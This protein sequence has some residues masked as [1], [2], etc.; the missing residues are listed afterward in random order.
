MD[1]SSYPPLASEVSPY[2]KYEC[3]SMERRDRSVF[4]NRWGAV[5]SPP[6]KLP[7][8]PHFQTLHDRQKTVHLCG[9]NPSTG[10]NQLV[11]AA[12][13]CRIKYSGL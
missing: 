1:R 2:K 8:S 5:G 4:H 9:W 3:V 10:D 6:V 7:F 11:H 12:A 13:N